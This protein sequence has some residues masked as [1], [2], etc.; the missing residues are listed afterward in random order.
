M[1]FSPIFQH[2]LTERFSQFFQE[3][4]TID[5][6]EAVPGGDISQTYL[7]HTTKGR[8]FVKINASLFGLDFFEK[9]ARGL[10]MLA[11][12][13]TLKV[14]RPLFDGK[15]HQQIYLVMEYLEKGL[16]AADFWEDFGASLA[17]LHRHTRD[18]FGLDY[19]NYIG[20]LHQANENRPSWQEFYSTQRIMPLV[21]KAERSKLLQ[22]ENVKQAETI[23]A[24][25]S[26]IIPEERPALIHGDLWKGNYMVCQSGKAAIYDPSMYFGHREM[27]LAIARLFGGFDERF[28]L[29]YEEASPLHSGHRDRVDI[30]QLY[31]LLVHLLLFGSQYR[32]LVCEIL[33]KY[34]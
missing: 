11:N 15:F 31:H 26:S 4:V 33:K 3:P 22:P 5:R 30:F 8:F 23:C 28:Y 17:A 16:P 9:E 13:G 2:H 29:A 12:S 10:A 27:D 34:A 1:L 24:K 20:K 21:C 18:Q 32:S 7:V 25:L 19:G 14:P 6:G